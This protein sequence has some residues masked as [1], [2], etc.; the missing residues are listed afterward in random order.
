MRHDH[1]ARIG[2]EVQRSSYALHVT[3]VDAPR[4]RV[5]LSGVCETSLVQGYLELSPIGTRN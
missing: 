5:C 2:E 4:Q 3:P 1:G